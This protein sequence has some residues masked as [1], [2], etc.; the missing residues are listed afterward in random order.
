LDLGHPI[1]GVADVPAP[2]LQHGCRNR[3]VDEWQR[4]GKWFTKG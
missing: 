1:D 3:R 2:F 4:R